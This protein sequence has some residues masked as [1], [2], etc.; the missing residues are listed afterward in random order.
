MSFCILNPEI[1]NFSILLFFSIELK[2]GIIIE[3]SFSS[4]FIII[5]FKD[6]F[7][8]NNLKISSILL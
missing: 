2:L 7:S 5:V 6:V 1:F 3:K 8:D 4:V